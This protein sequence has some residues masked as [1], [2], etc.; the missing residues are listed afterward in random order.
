MLYRICSNLGILFES[1]RTTKIR[2]DKLAQ[3]AIPCTMTRTLLAVHAGKK[4]YLDSLIRARYN[5]PGI[6]AQFAFEWKQWSDGKYSVK[7]YRIE[8]N[9]ETKE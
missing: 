5:H 6:A 9:N 7:V 4:A 1:V 3:T 2:L 8:T